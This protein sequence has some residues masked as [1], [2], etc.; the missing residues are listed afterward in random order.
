MNRIKGYCVLNISDKVVYSAKGYRIYKSIDEGNSWELDGIVDDLRFSIIANAS[1]LAARLFRAE[2]TAL[3]VL[4]DGS[5]IIIGKKGIF[6]AAP[7]E[8]L[9][10]KIFSIP[11][12]TRPLNIC[13]D[14][15]G[16]LYFGEYFSNPERREV[17]IYA[18]YDRGETWGVCYTFGNNTIRHVHGVF[19]DPIE[20]LVWFATGDLDGE[21]LIGN[22][23]DGFKT[24]NIFK[25]GGQSYRTVQLFFYQDF[26]VY[27]TD[28]EYEKNFIYRID[29]KDGKEY[30]L[31]EIQG[32]VLSGDSNGHWAVVATAVEP[33]T[34]NKDKFSHVWYSPDGLK[35]KELEKFE[36][37]SL[38]KKYF[39][40]GRIKFPRNAIF[41]NKLYCAGNALKHIDSNTIVL[42]L[43]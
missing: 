9:Y 22:T 10:K 41:N 27:A 30:C 34:V 16:H 31:K 32:S 6:L 7:G 21:C 43:V 23:S 29:R 39:Q 17:H 14:N 42:D 37:D 3:S 24:V 15:K 5:R 35:W 20:H 33:S 25:E 11:R 18:S 4:Q 8:R 1:R 19:Y 2:I 28:T 13:E 36:K 38:S 26:I 40:Y 12:G